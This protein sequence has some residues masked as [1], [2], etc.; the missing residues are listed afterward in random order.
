MVLQMR[1]PRLALSILIGA[2]IAVSGDGSCRESARNDLASPDTVGVNAGSGLGMM[3]LLVVFPA[4]AGQSPLL[5]S[6]GAVVGAPGRQRPWSL[7]WHTGKGRCLPSRLLLIGVA[8]GFGAQAAMLLFSLRMSFTMY[9]YVVTWM[10]G[11]LAAGTWTSVLLLLPC[12]LR[13]DSAGDEPVED[14]RPVFPRRRRG[15]KSRRG[16]RAPAG[17]AL[18]RRDDA[19]RRVRGH[20]RAHRFLGI[21]GTASCP[22]ADRL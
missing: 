4:A 16:G 18:G 19:L 14:A 12:C 15:G 2:G 7:L 5:V 22:P 13:A 9:N 21:G 1:L 3:L 17:V 8:I 6:L 11:T 10:S 20:R